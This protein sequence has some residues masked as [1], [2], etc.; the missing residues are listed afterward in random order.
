MGV[1][2]VFLAL[3]GLV[4]GSFLNVVAY[5]LPIGENWISERSRCPHC[6]T[7]IAAYD[8]IPVV[9]WLLLR[10][11]CRN[12]GAPISVRYPLSEVGLAAAFVA[13]WFRFQPDGWLV[14]L[15]CVFV[16]TLLVVTLTDLEDRI[17]PN[18]V[19]L[20]SLVAAIVLSVLADEGDLLERAE[21]GAIA[22]AILFIAALL[23]GRGMGMGDVKLAG[24]MGVYL[25]RAVAPALF[26]AFL[27][28]A[29]FGLGLIAVRGAEARKQAV[30]FGPFLALGGLVG[31]FAGDEIV[32]WYTDSFFN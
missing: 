12:C 6:K 20:A 3:L 10:G 27:T 28:G 25:G 4:L 17:I 32:D 21:A 19:L 16:A 1:E 8:N 24:L 15:G 26:A 22:F 2:V 14:A 31:L 5:R 23:Y 7:E 9:S 30:P 13:V 11:K 29:I 18:E